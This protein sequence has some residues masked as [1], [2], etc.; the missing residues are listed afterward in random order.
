MVLEKTGRD[1]R[2]VGVIGLVALLLTALGCGRAPAPGDT[3]QAKPVDTPN[4]Q[5]VQ[6]TV[7]ETPREP[8][9]VDVA[10]KVL[11]LRTF[12]VPEGAKLLGKPTLGALHYEIK[13]ETKKA[14]ELPRKYL[15]EHGW[16][17]LPGARVEDAE[18]RAEFTRDGF[19]AT[20]SASP[21]GENT[22]LILVSIQ[23]YGNVRASQVPVPADLKSEYQGSYTASFV[24]KTAKVPETADAIRKLLVDKGWTP[25]GGNTYDSKVSTGQSME[26]KRNAILLHV[27]VSTHENRPGETMIQYSTEVISADLPAP[28]NVNANSLRYF[29]Q[30]RTLTFDTTDKVDNVATFYRETLGKQGWKP[31]TDPK[32][33]AE[34]TVFFRNPAK[35]M[36]MLKVKGRKSPTRVTVRYY[37]AAE[38]TELDRKMKEGDERKEKEKPKEEEKPK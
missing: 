1:R 22:G 14:F 3:P 7:D 30:E 17:E 32:G 15:T 23:N 35:E 19:V 38:M 27:S 28:A 25:Y 10:A 8:A 2:R 29:D 24:T 5:P 26:F 6:V 16:K 33:V 11:D 34:M 21:T 13:D 37:T 18:A 12:P 20:V 36:I 31:V 4:A 9:T